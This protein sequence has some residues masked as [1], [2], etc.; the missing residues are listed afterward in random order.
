MAQRERTIDRPTEEPEVGVGTVRFHLP[1]GWR[2]SALAAALVAL[3]ALP[4]AARAADTPAAPTAENTATA[5]RVFEE[6]FTNG[7]L[8]L[9][10]QTY[11]EDF[12][13]DSRSGGKTPAFVRGAVAGWRTACP[14][15]KI[16]VEDAVA[17][18]DKVVVRWTATGTQA[19]TFSGLPPTGKHVRVTGL[20]TFRFRGGKIDHEWTQ[21]DWLGLYEQL[22]FTL[23]PPKP[24]S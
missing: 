8:D 19:G 22:G 23:T 10:E 15:L 12:V 11:T 17:E 6:I 21:F 4:A 1:S 16:A 5:R 20:T 7:K 18:G 2:R 13:D 24:A 9:I 14:D 3:I